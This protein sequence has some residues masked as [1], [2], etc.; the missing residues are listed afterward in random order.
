MVRMMRDLVQVEGNFKP[1][2]QL[3]NDF[4]N[5]D[6]NRHFVESYIPTQETL[7]IFLQIRDSLQPHSEQRARLFSGTYGTGKSDLM[8]MIANYVTRSSQDP[9]LAPFFK[10]LRH[11]NDAKAEAIYQARM[12]KPP[13]LLVLLQAD[14]AV[15]FSSF[16]LD[17]LAKSLDKVGQSELLGLTYYKAALDLIDSWEHNWPDNIRRLNEEL[18]ANYGRSLNQLRHDLSGP[19]A[20]TA[21][22]IFRPA[23]FQATGMPFHP[24]AVIQRPSE[25]FTNVAKKLASSKYCGIFVIADEFTHLLKKLADTPTALDSK[26]IDNLAEAA[27]RSGQYQLHFYTVSLESFASAQGSTKAS[28]AALERTGGRFTTH[29]LRSQN[30]EE[31]ISASIAKLVP[32]ERLF[33]SIVGQ[34]DDL[35]NF[36]MKLWNGRAIGRKDREWLNETVIRG[37]FPLHPLTTYCLPRLNAVLAQNERTM[38]SFIWDRSRGLGRFIEETSGEVSANGWLPL[39]SLD[40]LFAYFEAN[41]KEKRPDLLMAYQQASSTL[42]TNQ[43]DNGLEGRLLRALVMLEVAEGD[44]SLRAN[45]ELLRHALALAPSQGVEV[46]IALTQLEQNGIAYP[47]QSGYY[48]LV[49]PGRTN[50]LE[51]RRLIQQRSQ[52]LT[53]SPIELL[54]AQYRPN[55]IYA[56]RYNSERGTVRQ[57]TARFVSLAELSNPSAL[58]QAIDDRDALLWYV[59]ATSEQEL[60]QARTTALQLTRLNDQLVIAVPQQPTDLVLRFQRLRALKDLRAS[61]NYASSDYQDLLIDSGLVGKDFIT[62][63]NEV[64][65]QIDQP[66]KFDWFRSGRS[67]SVN[68]P[69]NLST[70]ATTVMNEVFSATPTHKIP[71]HLK[72]TGKSKYLRDALDQIL[73]EE[74]LLAERKKSATDSILIDGAGELGLI[75]YLDKKGAFKVYHACPPDRQQKYSYKVWQEIHEHLRAGTLWSNIVEEL[76]KRPYG[77]YPSVL[78]IFTAAFYRYNRDYLEVYLTVGASSHPIDITGDTIIDMIETPNRYAVRFQPLTELQYKFLRGFVERALYPN[79]ENRNLPRDG[80]VSLR[81]SV[82]M[83]LRHWIRK[84]PNIPRQTSTDELASVLQG[85]PSKDLQVCKLLIDI[86][87]RPDDAA[88]AADLLDILPTQLGLP[89]DSSIWTYTDLDQ[90]LAYLESACQYLQKFPKIFESHMAWQIAQQFGLSE[91]TKDLND[92]LR[93]AERWRKETVGDVQIIHLGG[94]PDG[95]DL[96]RFLED[97]PYSFEQVFLNALASRW[98]KVPFQEWRDISIKNEYLQHLAQAK[99]AVEE[100]VE[101]LL[102]PAKNKTVAPVETKQLQLQP[103]YKSTNPIPVPPFESKL[104]IATKPNLVTPSPTISNETQVLDRISPVEKPSVHEQTP[105]DTYSIVVDQAFA[106]I[107]SIIDSLSPK[108]QRQL[109][110]YLVQEY[111]PR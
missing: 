30:M 78:E 13:F 51:L 22:D 80:A 99:S 73:Q 62:A 52:E 61:S 50:P 6:Y 31:L 56:E 55:D 74:I 29:D 48:Q 81:N 92:V 57:L 53:G 102:L 47:S 39:L 63:F 27:V 101:L 19:H 12:D 65:K 18:E 103:T 111:D 82:A 20:D 38:F 1:S 54:N 9:L 36:T 46:S 106:K 34:F 17:G 68:T 100:A 16:V 41:L 58:V 66:S 96:L 85:V 60:D 5:E 35:L 109:W 67:V 91:P 110:E 23:A 4:L 84:I 105:T 98:V 28:Q 24:N 71:Q 21:L 87:F 89:K 14:T 8:L 37:C 83:L 75:Y 88:T 11:L 95:R 97:R 76:L 49:K 108:D 77:L 64:L 69:A 94:S 26:A 33:Q 43:L 25:A 90:A 44:S 3:P 104:D 45:H 15:T 7:D 40:K 2:V 107:K 32:V 86:A 42:S 59:I 10:R 70:L 79:R 93:A 72:S